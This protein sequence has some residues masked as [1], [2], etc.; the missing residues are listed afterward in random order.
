MI[1]HLRECA[2]FVR[3]HAPKMFPRDRVI[4]FPEFEGLLKSYGPNIAVPNWNDPWI[5]EMPDEDA[6]LFLLRWL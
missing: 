4:D 1:V 6:I 5:V 2:R 3:H